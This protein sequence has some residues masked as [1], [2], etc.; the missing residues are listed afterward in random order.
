MLINILLFLLFEYLLGI[1]CNY[2][3]FRFVRHFFD[4][5]EFLKNKISF[6]IFML[7]S[8]YT[9][10]SFYFKKDFTLKNFLE[11]IKERRPIRK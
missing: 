11:T 1:F 3:L 10:I 5:I 7:G 2:I 4:N 9:I 8:W 6:C